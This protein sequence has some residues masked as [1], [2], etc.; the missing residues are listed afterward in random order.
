MNKILCPV[1]FSAT[2]VSAIQFATEIGAKFHSQVT[3]VNVFTERDFNKVV[4]EESV[5]KSF[6]SLIAMAKNK[7]QVLVDEVNEEFGNKLTCTYELELGPFIDSI[8]RL[9]DDEHFDLIVMGTTGVSK[10]DGIFFGSNTAD[11]I[12]SSKK[13]HDYHEG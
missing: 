3:L 12:D 10:N 2:S 4:G 5:G 11:I 6:K 1:D 8:E 9:V 13:P 7:L